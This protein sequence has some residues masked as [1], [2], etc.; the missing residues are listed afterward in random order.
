MAHFILIMTEE[1]INELALTF[2]KEI[3]LLYRLPESIASDRNIRLM[4]KFWTILMQL[5]QVKL[6][7]STTFHPES[8]RQT[9]RVNQT[10]EQ[11]LTSYFTY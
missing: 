6:N 1:H 4:S 11:Y 7:L 10:L 8:D 9:K 5:V 3:W 2:V